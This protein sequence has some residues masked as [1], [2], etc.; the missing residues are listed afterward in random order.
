MPATRTDGV[1]GRRLADDLDGTPQPIRSSLLGGPLIPPWQRRASTA[2]SAPPDCGGSPRRFVAAVLINS[3]RMADGAFRSYSSHSW[4]RRI[5]G[6]TYFAIK[7]MQLVSPHL[8]TKVLSD[9]NCG[10]PFFCRS[11]H[12]IGPGSQVFGARAPVIS[13]QEVCNDDS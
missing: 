12:S 4:G 2:G 9:S 6:I 1:R 3:G 11:G 10:C 8:L 5:D 13:T 7:V